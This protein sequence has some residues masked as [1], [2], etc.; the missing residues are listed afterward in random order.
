M[1]PSTTPNKAA[2]RARGFTLIEV[3]MA[4]TILTIGILGVISMQKSAVVAN[5][6]AQQFTVATQIARTWVD[7]L[8]RDASQWTAPNVFTATPDVGNTMWLKQVVSRPYPNWFLPIQS[9]ALGPVESPAFDRNGAEVSVAN[10]ATLADQ[11]VYCTHLRLRW[12]YPNDLI[13]AEVRVFW[14]KRGMVKSVAAYNAFGLTNGI[15]S[16]SQR[17]AQENAIGQDVDDFHWVYATT[18]IPR[19]GPK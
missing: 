17:S 10:T 5:S 16:E 9:T 1:A 19:Q 2:P 3:M 15:C 18:A 14:R 7:R 11:T 6:D 4:L 13:R 12:V 8:H